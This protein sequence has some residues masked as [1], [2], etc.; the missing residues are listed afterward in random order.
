V[1]G[2]TGHIG[3]RGDEDGRWETFQFEGLDSDGEERTFTF[4]DR[5]LPEGFDWEDFF[6]YIEAF[7]DDYDIDYH[8]PYE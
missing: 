5:D 8:N 2:L 7:I 4:T 1:L 3:E 6:D